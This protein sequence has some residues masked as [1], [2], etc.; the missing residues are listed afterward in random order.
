MSLWLE[1][2][3]EAIADREYRRL[4]ESLIPCCP[5]QL[6]QCMINEM[7]YGERHCVGEG[8]C[9]LFP[10]RFLWFLE[11]IEQ[12]NFGYQARERS[13]YDPEMLLQMFEDAFNNES[14][15]FQK[16]ALGIK[17][18]MNEKA[19]NAAGEWVYIGN[20]F[21]ADLFA[22]E[23]A[24]GVEILFPTMNGGSPQPAFVN[25]RNGQSSNG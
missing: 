6:P 11:G 1:S 2:A 20:S 19:I 22:I 7:E 14:V 5:I 23:S 8:A 15:R 17:F 9:P 24:V 3:L 25:L 10:I 16:E 18:D 4:R 13:K 12:R 21:A